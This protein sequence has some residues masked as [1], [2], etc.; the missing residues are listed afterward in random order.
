MCIICL[1]VYDV[2]NFEINLIFLIK[3]SNKIFSEQKELSRRNKK[4][5]SK[6]FEELSLKQIKSTFLE[7]ESP[8]FI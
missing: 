3:V 7:G 1:T 5:F 4:H 6:S 2:I 8:T